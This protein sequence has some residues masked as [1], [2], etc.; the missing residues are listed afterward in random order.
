MKTLVALC[1]YVAY[2]NEQLLKDC[3]LIP[4]SFTNLGYQVRLVTARKEEFTYLK[5]LPK[6]K[7]DEAPLVPEED[8]ATYLLNYLKN[9]QGQIDRL[10][11]F[12]LREAYGPVIS[13]FKEHFDGKVI[14]KLDANSY[15][16]DIINY[17]ATPYQEIIAA[18][19]LISCE[20]QAMQS[21]L[22]KKWKRP[23]DLIRNGF[24]LATFESEL[25]FK[26]KENI[27]LNVGRQESER[28]NSPAL[29]K[30]FASQ[31]EKFPDWQLVLIGNYTP[32]VELLVKAY[33]QRN[34]QLKRQLKLLGP[35]A[36][37]KLL[38]SYYAKAKIFV[39]ASYLEGGSPN[40]VAE[41]LRNGCYLI[42][43]K[44]DAWQDTFAKGAGV[45]FDH[46]DLAALEANMCQVMSEPQ[47]SQ[48]AFELNRAYALAEL[49]YEKQ[50]L[51]LESL[52]K[53]RGQIN[54]K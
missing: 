40:V 18:C 35:I 53:V 24:P 54:G 10:F 30:A 17:Q 50:V 13:Y 3:V 45:S 12:G 34:P 20:G 16:M 38:E 52:L 14:L 7:I 49:P 39:T 2:R 46:G 8:W 25:D 26:Q 44:I 4:Y 48:R 21:Y 27:I 42:T 15:W 9:Y 1:P 43:S 23:I 11:C 41:A 28:K 47:L 19:D 51:R 5:Y 37:K 36:D 29:I 6:L 32:E 31:A 22:T 33:Q